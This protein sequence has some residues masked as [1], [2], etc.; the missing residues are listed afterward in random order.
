MGPSKFIGYNISADDY[1]GSPYNK[2]RKGRVP[3]NGGAVDKLDGR[4]TE[5]VLER[6]ADL[7][8]EGDENYE[9]LHLALSALCAK[10][11]KKPSALARISILRTGPET[12]NAKD[13]SDEFVAFMVAAYRKLSSAQRS[14]FRKLISVGE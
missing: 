3:S 4:V 8:E 9:S 7:V 5:K 2:E 14:A 11:G 1:L 10:Y 6:W 13:S 12:A